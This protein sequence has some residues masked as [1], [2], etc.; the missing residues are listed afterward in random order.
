LKK[1]EAR[2]VYVRLFNQ[3]TKKHL[4]SWLDRNPQKCNCGETLKGK[5]LK[6]DVKHPFGIPIC[7]EG[8]SWLYLK[9]PK[10]QD[11]LPWLKWVSSG[12]LR[13]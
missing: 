13:N 4:K 6:F 3:F 11:V 1:E 8:K 7:G 9:C 10:C 2:G 12:F 5:H